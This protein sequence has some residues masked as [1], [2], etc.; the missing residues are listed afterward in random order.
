MVRKTSGAWRM[1]VDYADLNKAYPKD[2]F[3]LTRIDLLVDATSGHQMLSFMDAYSGYNQIQMDP[4]DEEATSFQT[5]KGLYCYLVM[6]FGLKNAGATYQRLMN[7]VFKSLIGRT[8]EVYMDDML[9]KSLE[10]SQHILDLE[11]CFCL[12]RSY[13]MRLNPSKCAFGVTSGK[14]LGFMVT[15]RGI[16]ANPKKIKA[17]R[18]MLPPRNIKEVQRMN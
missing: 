2:S 1:C 10:K 5:D 4:A 6:P 8:I 14:F 18:D 13:N 16:E 9:V 12:L 17:L 7:K 11:E 3:P 15:H